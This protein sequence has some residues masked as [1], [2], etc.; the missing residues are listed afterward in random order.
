MGSWVV[1]GPRLVQGRSD[2]QRELLDVESVAG[3]FHRPGSVFDFLAEH[4]SW[5][6]PSELFE[7]LF[8]SRR[9]R[10]SVPGEVVATVLV[11]QSLYKLSDRETVETLTFD[12]RWQAACGLAVTDT[13][14][15]PLMVTY[16]CRQLASRP[17]RTAS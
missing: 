10:P 11:L 17:A 12:L 4:R 8:P 7:D 15:D 3:P 2:A 6:F 5:L 16:W 1:L 9:G 14:F 13:R